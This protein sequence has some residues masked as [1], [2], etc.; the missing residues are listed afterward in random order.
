M[1]GGASSKLVEGVKNSSQKE[2]NES[3]QDLS[4]EERSRILSAITMLEVAGSYRADTSNG[5]WGDYSIKVTIKSS[6]DASV[7]I[8]QC[9]FRDSPGEDFFY[10]GALSAAGDLLTF[11]SSKVTNSLDTPFEDKVE[12]M[13]FKIQGDGSLARLNEDG[14]VAQIQGGYDGTPE[15]AILKKMSA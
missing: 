13:K 3:M 2:L 12:T 14:S 10:E 7:K 11:T 9:F 4:G 15:P 1:G 8:S 5:D 6:G